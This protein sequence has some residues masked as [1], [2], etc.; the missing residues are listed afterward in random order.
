VGLFG[1]GE[2]RPIIAKGGGLPQRIMCAPAP[3]DRAPVS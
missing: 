2:H 1:Y 3:S